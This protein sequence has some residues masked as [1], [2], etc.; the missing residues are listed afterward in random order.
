MNQV[1]QRALTSQL[2]ES[3][4]EE[5][6]APKPKAKSKAKPAAKSNSP[7]KKPTS[8]GKAKADD[9]D[10]KPK[11]KSKSVYRFFWKADRAVSANTCR[12]R[13]PVPAIRAPRTFQRA[14]RTAWPV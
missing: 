6:E 10:E 2:L 11:S 3:D 9:E 13:R 14:S 1:A 12:T 5:E 7:E 8:K 4:S